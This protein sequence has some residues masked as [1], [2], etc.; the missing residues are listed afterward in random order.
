MN[1]N[2]ANTKVIRKAVSK[3][4]YRLHSI[5]ALHFLFPLNSISLNN[6]FKYEKKML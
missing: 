5:E 3:R 1:I 2:F 6:I 4:V